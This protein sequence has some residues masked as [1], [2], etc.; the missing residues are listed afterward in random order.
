MEQRE[1]LY[2]LCFSD[3]F[4]FTTRSAKFFP[5]LSLSLGVSLMYRSNPSFTLI[6]I[7]IRIE[8]VGWNQSNGRDRNRHIGHMGPLQ[9][10]LFDLL[11]LDNARR[12]LS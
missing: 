4:A 5:P 6:R 1:T 12:V 7:G 8:T 9:D 10:L 3:L 2:I 11:T